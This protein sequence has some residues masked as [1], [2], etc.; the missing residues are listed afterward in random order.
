MIPISKS[1]LLVS[2]AGGIFIGVALFD[3]LPETIKNLG[4][5]TTLFWLLIGYVGWRTIKLVLQKF[6]KPA[7]SFLTAA[8]REL[9]A[10]CFAEKEV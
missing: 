5:P 8:A 4:I 2:L 7:L 6:K 9:R 1:D 3:V 10:F